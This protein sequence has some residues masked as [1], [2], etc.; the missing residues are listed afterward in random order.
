MKKFFTFAIAVTAML[1]SSAADL[2]VYNNGQLAN[3]INVYGWYKAAMDFNAT[4][5]EVVDAKVFSFKAED[6]GANASM[7]LFADGKTFVTGPLNSATL[8]FSWFAFGTGTY[9]IR[10]TADGGPEEN[11]SFDVTAENAEKW[12]T[13]ALPIS[14]LYP[15]VATA[16][17]DYAGKGAGYVFAVVGTDLSL[18]A[19][20]Y[21]SDIN[22][23]NLDESWTAPEVPEIVPPTTVPGVEQPADK[24]LS[25]FSADGKMAYNIGGWDQS[26][27]CENVTIDGKEAIKLTSFNYLG[28]EFP[29]HINAEGYDYMH[30]DFYPCEET[31]FG[32][33][34]ISPGPQEKGWKAPEVKLNEWNGYDVPLSYF[35]NVA[36]N[37]IFQIKFD[38]GSKVECYLANVYFYKSEGG[39]EPDVP[40][41]GATY[42]DSLTGTCTQ[43]L[44]AGEPKDY[45]YTLNYSITY[46]EDKTLTV[47]SKF[48]WTNGEPVGIVPGTIF[49]DNKPFDFVDQNG[50]R[51]VT[52]TETYEAGAKIPVRLYI[53]MALGVIETSLPDYVVGSEK[54]GG[55]E[56]DDPTPDDPVTGAKYTGK[57]TGEDKITGADGEEVY[58]YTLNYTIAYNE[59]KTLTITAELEWADNKPV[60]GLVDG[61]VFINGVNN[62]F[63]MN[64]NVRTTTTADTYNSGETL[65]MNFYFPRYA[66][67]L[68]IPV[69]YVV[70]TDNTTS[71]STITAPV[72]E[73]GYYDLRGIRVANPSNGLYIR[74]ENGKATKVYVK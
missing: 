65:N 44:T 5:P 63:T 24:V 74:V 48:T 25:V 28:W 56:P 70:G 60:T 72:I 13:M 51:T 17:K 29:E 71:I 42:S 15:N 69:S 53:A 22:Y 64:N 16:W 38:Q 36:L 31:E 9:T 33:T 55:E 32:F 18:D 11:Y 37:D 49:I 41:T 3:G 19:T 21:F 14:E 2:T 6:Y 61:N 34:P 20:I 50:A 43:E 35:S 46:N 10:L 1:S 23:S 27:V 52:T 54:Q 67:V 45:P 66:G 57:V 12:N 59:D 30:V 58:P 47:V 68:E 39:D 8:N 7:G 62:P 4:A 73:A 40:G 26:T